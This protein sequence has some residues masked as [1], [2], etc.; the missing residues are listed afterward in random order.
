LYEKIGYKR[1]DKLE[2]INDKIHWFFMRKAG[3]RL[4]ETKIAVRA[5]YKMEE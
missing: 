2:K 1:T 3:F 4:V 5:M